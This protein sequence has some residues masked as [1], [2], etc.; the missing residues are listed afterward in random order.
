M[1]GNIVKKEISSTL[2]N[3]IAEANFSIESVREK[4]LAAY[5]YAIDTEGLTPKEAHDLLK[6]RLVFSKRYIREVLPLEAKETRFTHTQEEKMPE[7]EMEESQMEESPMEEFRKQKGRQ[8]EEEEDDDLSKRI[9]DEGAH[10]R[11]LSKEDAEEA[12]EREKIEQDLIYDD[13][14]KIIK[15]YEGRIVYLSR[16]F[17]R[18]VTIEVRDQI[19]PLIVTVDPEDK[20]VTVALDKAELKNLK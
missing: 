1:S 15:E 7:S 10:R 5:N 14:H 6:D 11:V 19:I 13:P 8:L 17:K 18:N 20:D 4:I 9:P 12:Q 16:K 3:L 2:S